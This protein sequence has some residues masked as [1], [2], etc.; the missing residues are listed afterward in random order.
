MAKVMQRQIRAPW[1]S[2]PNGGWQPIAGFQ[3]TRWLCVTEELF[4]CELSIS[5]TAMIT[6]QF[7]FGALAFISSVK[8]SLLF[9]QE[10]WEEAEDTGQEEWEQN[11]SETGSWRLETNFDPW[12]FCIR[13]APA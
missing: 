13:S 4:V 12:P 9:P 1:S 8:M 5:T 11:L 10:R 3:S 7:T 6:A 2:C